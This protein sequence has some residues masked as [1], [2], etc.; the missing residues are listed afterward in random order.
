MKV[1]VTGGAG[2]IGSHFIRYL[3][4]YAPD[5]AIVNLDALTYAGRL[6]NLQDVSTHPRHRFQ[7]GDIA[8]P[9]ALDA[10]FKTER[11]DLVVNLAAESHVDRSILEAGVF[12][13]TN[14]L[15]VQALLEAARKHSVRRFCQVSTD[16]VYG[17]L[18]PQDPPVREDAPL[19]PNS[20]YS[21]SKAAADLLCRAH[22]RTY[23]LD[24]VVTRC[25]NN[26]GPR[27]FPEKLIPRFITLALEDRELPLYGDGENVRDWL[28]VEDHCAGLWA[29]ALRG[30]PG[31]VYHFGGRE[32][33]TNLE[34]ARAILSLLG[35]PERLIRRVADRPG[36]DRRYALDI[37]RSGRELGW[38]PAIP[39]SKG[40]TATVE[41]YRSHRGW[42]EA[43][44]SG[45]YRA[46]S[47]G[48]PGSR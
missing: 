29:A 21:A 27:Q 3:L 17:S 16:E 25:C 18:G 41:W 43:I 30:R 6:E 37:A 22:V 15:G 31:E 45:S 42:W 32:E 11:F 44:G 2:F 39:F 12:L 7:R 10:L 8:D 48:A 24:V 28:H 5:V 1:L 20:P 23:G 9:V 4:Q 47:D 35:R 14:V 40:L 33:R 36:H 19:R 26:Y 38:T 46:G 34:V 13:R